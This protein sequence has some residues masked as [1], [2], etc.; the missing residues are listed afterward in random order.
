MKRVWSY[1]KSLTFVTLK[2]GLFSLTGSSGL[3][4]AFRRGNANNG[5][6]A[7]LAYLNGDNGVSSANVNWSSPLSF[8]EVT[9]IFFQEKRPR[10]LAKKQG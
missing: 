10:P 2:N 4:A 8:A 9:Q 3:R 7:G 5:T 6:N 1:R